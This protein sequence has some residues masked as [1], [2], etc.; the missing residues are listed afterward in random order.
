MFIL[1]TNFSND[2]NLINRL[3]SNEV[4]QRNK[5]SKDPDSSLKDSISLNQLAPGKGDLDSNGVLDFNDS[6]ILG[7][8]L[9]PDPNNTPEKLSE[10]QLKKADINNDGKV[11]YGDLMILSST[12]NNMIISSFK[13]GSSVKG[14]LNGDGKVNNDDI[15]I[16][17]LTEY[18]TLGGAVGTRPSDKLVKAVDFNEDGILNNA[19]L[20]ILE[21]LLTDKSDT[22]PEQSGRPPNANVKKG[23]LNQDGRVDDTDLTILGDAINNKKLFDKLTEDQKQAADL[24]K[25]GKINGF[26]IVELQKEIITNSHNSFN[27]TS[28]IIGDFNGDSILDDNDLEIFNEKRISYEYFE[29]SNPGNKDYYYEHIKGLLDFNMDGKVTKADKDLFINKI[30]HKELPKIEI[31]GEINNDPKNWMVSQELGF[32]NPHVDKTTFNG[33]CA[34]TSLVMIAR[35]FGKLGGGPEEA[36]KQIKYV[37]ELAGVPNEYTGASL[38]SISDAAE[39]LGLKSTHTFGDINTIKFSLNSGKKLLLNVD[40]GKY[41]PGGGGGHAIVVSGFKD[42]M[43]EVYDPGF[44]RPIKVSEKTLAEAMQFTNGDMLIIGKS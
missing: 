3:G 23:D 41:A 13:P 33:N 40:P 7:D 28:G 44:Q 38:E 32:T 18:L 29:S 8:Y 11:N 12:L 14:D 6:K 34:P 9:Y 43:F 20:K 31:P 36:Q 42:G 22:L 35:M 10:D 24:S 27:P 16:T 37:R 17:V 26:D 1:N 39:S 4:N 15:N 19:D 5:N 2:K 30:L 25:D 21:S